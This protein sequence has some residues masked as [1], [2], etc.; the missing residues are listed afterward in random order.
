MAALPGVIT[1][2]VALFDST[3]DVPVYDGPTVTGDRPLSYVM[4]G[5]AEDESASL[6]FEL[7]TLGPGTWHD[8]AGEVVCTIASGSG[9]SDAATARA[10]ALA[11]L[12]QIRDAIT[13]DR[14]LGGALPLNGLGLVGRAS[15]T[16]MQTSEGVMALV[17]FAVPYSTTLTA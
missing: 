3:L 5:S 1:A 12:E 17:S 6:T 11:L 7:S 13:A 9:G 8:E 4:V 10:T 14:T 15:L 2:L 16:Q